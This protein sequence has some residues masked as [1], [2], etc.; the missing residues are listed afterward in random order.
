MNMKRFFMLFRYGLVAISGI[1]LFFA[2]SN[3]AVAQAEKEKDNEAYDRLQW[4]YHQRSFPLDTMEQGYLLKAY[5]EAQEFQKNR[6]ARQTASLIWSPVGPPP[7]GP[8][9][10]RVPTVAL[11]PTDTNIVY[12]GAANGGVW[13]STNAGTVWSPLTDYQPSLASG[14]LA[15]NPKNSV[16]IYYGTGE[17]YNASDAYGGA[18]IFK[19]TDGGSTWLEPTLTSEKR[20]T[21][22][23]INPACTET[24]LASTWGGV[25]RSSN[26]GSTWTKRTAVSGKGWDVV[27]DPVDSTVAYACANNTYKS[28]DAGLTWSLLM[29][30]LPRS[31]SYRRV[32]ALAPS[33]PSTLYLF[34]QTGELY[35]SIDAGASWIQLHTPAGIV[36]TQ[37]WYNLAIAVSPKNPDRVMIGGV[38]VCYS[39]DGGDN[40]TQIA[41][42]VHPDCHSIQFD[43][44][45]SIVYIGHD[46]GVSRSNDSGATFTWVNNNLA[47]TQFYTV[48]VDNIRPGC[49]WGGS[50]DNGVLKIT[51]ETPWTGVLGGDCGSVCVDYGNSDTVYAVRS[52][53]NHFRSFDGSDF[54]P[55]D[56]GIAM[57][58]TFLTP[59]A[60]DPVSPE[61]LYTT[62]DSLIYRTTDR[63]NFWS[64]T[65]SI[66][67]WGTSQVTRIAVANKD[68]LTMYAAVNADLYRSSDT[69]STWTKIYSLAVSR[70]ITSVVP[71]PL[72][73]NIIYLTTAGTTKDHIYKSTDAGDT[74][75][76]INGDFPVSLPVNCI[77]IDPLDDQSLFI[78]TDL[79]LWETDGDKQ[80]WVKDNNIPN[81][82][83]LQLGIT[84]DRHI[85]AA[86]H[87]RSMFRALLKVFEVPAVTLTAPNGGEQWIGR[88]THE[89]AWT[90]TLINDVKIEYSL[91]SAQTWTLV[92]AA[93]PAVT[94][95]YQWE[96]PDTYTEKAFI[97][98]SDASNP[99]LYDD[100]DSVFTIVAA[101]PYVYDK[102]WNLVSLPVNQEGP[103]LQFYPQ[104]VSSAFRFSPTQGY[105][106]TDSVTPGSG[107]WLKFDTY[108]TD[109]IPGPV[110]VADTVSVYTGWNLIGALGVPLGVPEIITEPVG[111]ISSPVFGYKRGYYE[112]DSLKLYKAYWVK[113]TADGIVILQGAINGKR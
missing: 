4:F 102:R 57:T 25:Y 49:I 91:D 39:T 94:G 6:S 100:C 14:S 7:T 85:I 101:L 105:T 92:T 112:T 41:S 95:S 79:G 86:T 66:Y 55:I 30:G 62:G 81:T 26:G 11:D 110:H 84:S 73:Q 76:S 75:T 9:N 27:F 83:V 12:I 13:K 69:G 93:V 67:P 44:G 29:N 97:R 36:G 23:A 82:A 19:S 20:V 18:G 88:S 1:L 50:Q 61:I 63:G 38:L 90:H 32:F 103:T 22:I 17:P 53:G 59:M 56:S 74:W 99:A 87:G 106:A 10:G 34:Y 58:A 5:T 21:R 31:I 15:I 24:L 48:G 46:G 43:P 42:G 54:D 98:V 70:A 37:G 77:A 113:V 33:L 104:A 47:I 40:W 108:I 109:S 35:K 80:N 45:G 72:K 65:A 2:F 3:I 51:P 16:I 89:I 52:Y 68:S 71:H 64:P 28:T 111:I 78:G 8:N 96:V 60:M 107:Y